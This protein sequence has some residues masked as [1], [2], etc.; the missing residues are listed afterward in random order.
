MPIDA[1]ASLLERECAARQVVERRVLV[2]G[3][4][5]VEAAVP[6]Y[7]QGLDWLEGV[8]EGAGPLSSCAGV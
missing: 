8:V 7:T 2:D 4:A 1:T 6:A 3:P 5:H